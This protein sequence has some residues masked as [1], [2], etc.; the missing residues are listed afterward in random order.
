MIRTRLFML[1]FLL[2]SLP[3]KFPIKRLTKPLGVV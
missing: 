1:D 2:L 3:L